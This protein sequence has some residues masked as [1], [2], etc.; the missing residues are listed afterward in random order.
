MDG[1]S[2][3]SVQWELTKNLPGGADSCL[4]FQIFTLLCGKGKVYL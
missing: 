1:T 3:T 4:P 2:R